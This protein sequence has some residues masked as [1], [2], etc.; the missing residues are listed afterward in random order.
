LTYAYI[1]RINNKEKTE[2]SSMSDEE[3]KMIGH[4]VFRT[5]AEN[6]GR[7]REKNIFH[8]KTADFA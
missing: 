7:Q 2:L 8:K 5:M 4:L 6:S 1:V 3:Q